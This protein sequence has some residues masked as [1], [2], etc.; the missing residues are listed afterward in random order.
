[1]A[2]IDAMT[3]AI[4]LAN[5]DEAF[6]LAEKACFGHDVAS[7]NAFW[8]P[9]IQKAAARCGFQPVSALPLTPTGLADGLGLGSVLWQLGQCAP[10]ASCASVV[11]PCSACGAELRQ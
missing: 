9:E 5:D 8:P 6:E 3:A 4:G 1:M 2:R 7:R 11:P 10:E